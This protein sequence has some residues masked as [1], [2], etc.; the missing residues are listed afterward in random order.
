MADAGEVDGRALKPLTVT[1]VVVGAK[2]VGA[3]KAVAG[4]AKRGL[5]RL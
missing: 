5:K 2:V 4:G 1:P 3:K